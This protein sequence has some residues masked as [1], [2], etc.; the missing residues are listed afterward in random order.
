[1]NGDPHLLGNSR[2]IFL[3]VG[4]LLLSC[5]TYSQCPELLGRYPRGNVLTATVNSTYLYYGSGLNLVIAD[6]SDP[7]HP[8]EVGHLALP[9]IVNR[10]YVAHDYAYIANRYGGLRIINI[11]NPSSPTEVGVLPLPDPVQDVVVWGTHAYVASYSSGLRV[12][13][14]AAPSAP[15]QVGI[16]DTPG[17]AVAVSISGNY[18]YVADWT[19]GLRVIDIRTP[20]APSEVAFSPSPDKDGDVKV[21]GDYAY[22]VCSNS[23]FRIVDVSTPSSPTQVGLMDTPGTPNGLDVVGSYAYIAD[24]GYFRAVNISNPANPIEVGN[25]HTSGYAMDTVVSGGYA[26]VADYMGGLLVLDVSTPSSPT[27]VSST[28]PAWNAYGVHVKGN[29]AYVADANA[30]LRVMDVTDRS[31]PREVAVVDPTFGSLGLTI[32]DDLAYVAGSTS[33]LRIVDISTPTAPVIIGTRDTPGQAWDVA[34]IGDYAYVADGSQGVRII[35][36]SNPASPVEINSIST[37]DDVRGVSIWETRLY[38][39][40]QSAGMLIYDISTPISPV[41]LGYFPT[42]DLAMDVVA[43]GNTA[44]VAAFYDALRIVDVSNPASPF[45]VGFFDP[46]GAINHLTVSGNYA[47]LGSLHPTAGG[48]HIVDMSNPAAPV[49]AGSNT[50]NGDTE[51]IFIDGFYA[52]AA[53]EQDGLVIYSLTDCCSNP[54]GSFSLTTPPDISFNQACSLTLDWTDSTQALGYNIYLDT[55]TPPGIIE[56]DYPWSDYPVTLVPGT[57]YYWNVMAENGC[58]SQ[59]PAIQSFSTTPLPGSFDLVS[60]DDGATDQPNDVVLDWEPSAW[61]TSYSVYLGTSSPIPLYQDNITNTY[62]EL[63]GL[64]SSTTYTWYVVASNNCGTRQSAK[65][66]FTTGVPV[67]EYSYSLWQ[68]TCTVAGTGNGNDIAD[69]GESITLQVLLSNPGAFDVTNLTGTLATTNSNIMI[70]IDNSAFY[71][72]L[73]GMESLNI[74]PF[75]FDISE[76]TP[77]T[78]TIDFTLSLTADEG[79]WDIPFQFPI[80][81]DSGY[82]FR[83]PFDAWPPEGWQIVDHTGTCQWESTR[84]TGRPTYSGSHPG[85]AYVAESSDGL[86]LL[87]VSIPSDPINLY[88]ESSNVLY[89][90]AVSGNYA[91]TVGLNY[92]RVYDI[93]S[94]DPAQIGLFILP[95]SGFDVAIKGNY[96]Y[97]PAQYSGLRVINISIPASPTG[98]GFYDTPGN[99]TGVAIQGNYAFVAD[100]VTLQILNISTPAAPTFVSSLATPVAAWDLAVEGD[101]VYVADFTSLRIIDIST[102]N[103]PV[104]VGHIDLPGTI[105]DVAISGNYAYVAAHDGGLRVIDISTPS[106]PVEVGFTTTAEQARRVKVFNQLVYVAD[107]SLGLL[108]FDITNPAKPVLAGASKSTFIGRD[109]ALVNHA[110]DADSDWCGDGMDTELITPAI[111]IPG[112]ASATLNFTAAYRD[113]EARA[114]DYFHVDISTNGGTDW[115]NILSWNESHSPFG[116]GEEVS[117]DISAFAGSADTKIRFHYVATAWDWYALIDNV[118]IRIAPHCY[119][120]DAYGPPGESANDGSFTLA[121]N[122]TD[123]DFSWNGPGGGCD[124]SGYSLYTGDITSLAGGYGHDTPLVCGQA[125]TTFSLPLSD[126]DLNLFAGQY[127]LVVSGNGFQEGSYGKNTADDERP[128]SDNACLP[129]PQDTG[130]CTP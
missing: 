1:M 58:G 45:E 20:S 61:M 95:T 116:P 4:L 112:G 114:I 62:L 96:A 9:D 38:I 24:Y 78:S 99:S 108:I 80:G 103:I 53:N 92:F 50:S 19:S 126:A 16:I 87:D 109:I 32:R 25:Y 110:A 119:L 89:G 35:N 70:T 105:W 124:S 8:V 82:I 115:T 117:L 72:L 48:L 12:V 102:I 88:T 34:L 71:D 129:G 120:C 130:E 18:A 10:I 60:P 106:A 49:S 85:Y 121:K 90:I 118:N 30:G 98:A 55:V 13:N 43:H 21:I 44:Y 107:T 77:C 74:T 75:T 23:G 31:D 97:I 29:Y 2:I 68:D 22:V 123:L 11:S 52:Y 33:G 64:D 94:R 66:S 36:I 125:G 79:T 57:T 41:Y 127:F 81:R 14:I 73:A 5:I 27:P 65:R 93:S 7:A 86:R 15:V 111:Y 67:V 47:F 69:P 104:E 63:S 3:F 46:G 113:L 54:P 91:Y 122:G 83:E 28:S 76:L 59:A 17:N 84:T 56:S 100:G 39:A 101:Y 6:I 51:G 42:P 40:A 26:Y 37:A 128:V